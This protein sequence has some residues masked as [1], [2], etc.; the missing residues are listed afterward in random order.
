MRS[1]DIDDTDSPAWKHD[2]RQPGTHEVQ[3]RKAV[4]SAAVLRQQTIRSS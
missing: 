1:M 4:A 3:Q 2:G